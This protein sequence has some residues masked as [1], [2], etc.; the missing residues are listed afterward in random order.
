MVTFSPTCTALPSFLGSNLALRSFV[1]PSV[2]WTP[3]SIF[4]ASPPASPTL[5]QLLQIPPFFFSC[6]SGHVHPPPSHRH[7]TCIVYTYHIQC[8]C[9]ITLNC[10]APYCAWTLTENRFEII[11][12]DRRTGLPPAG[13]RT[14]IICH[15]R[16]C[17]RP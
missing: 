5:L 14:T 7:A 16:L 3:F 10:D 2:R 1:G 12:G 9:C 17:F 4:L 15:C 6:V 13:T 11:V 8:R